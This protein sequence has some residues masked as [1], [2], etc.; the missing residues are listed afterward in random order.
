[1]KILY[2][3]FMIILIGIKEVIRRIFIIII[4]LL[5][6]AYYIGR[7]GID[8]ASTMLEKKLEQMKRDA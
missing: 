4:T 2:L 6:M 8:D 7:Y 3:T 1:M 5:C